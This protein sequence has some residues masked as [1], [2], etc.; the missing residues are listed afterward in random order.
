MVD[1]RGEWDWGHLQGL[2]PATTLER[3]VACP[4]LK[5]F[6]GD[7]FPGWRWKDNRC[8]TVGSAYDYLV[9]GGHR[10]PQTLW[11][12]VLGDAH[13]GGGFFEQPFEAWL[14]NNLSSIASW[15][16]SGLDWGMCFSIWCWLLWKLRCSMVFDAEFSERDGVLNRV[17]RLIVECERMFR[18]TGS[19]RFKEARTRLGWIGPARGWVKLNVDAAVSSSDGRA[20]ISEDWE[21]V[22]RH[23]SRERNGMADS[24]AAMGRDHGR[25]GV[26]F[27]TPPGGLVSRLEEERAMWLSERVVDNSVSGRERESVVLFDPGG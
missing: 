2:L 9:V 18:M 3:L 23:I 19:E 25:S 11:L 4:I 20:S 21:V 27:V 6:F 12:R 1:G 22:V 16:R 15:Q 24:L 5:M 13:T 14:Q 10:Q 8:F 7:D 17:Y 26:V